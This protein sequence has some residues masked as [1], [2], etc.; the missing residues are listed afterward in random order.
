MLLLEMIRRL[1]RYHL[2][3]HD[4]AL[5]MI[6]SSGRPEDGVALFSHTL[7]ADDLWLARIEHGGQPEFNQPENLNDAKELLFRVIG[8]WH[9]LESRLTDEMLV[10]S[11]SYR[12]SKG[13]EYSQPLSDILMHVLNHGTH[14]RG[15]IAR[16]VRQAEGKPVNTDLLFYFRKEK[17]GRD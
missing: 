1:I 8:R 4:R 9:T 16:A 12:N 13:A 11:V 17:G 2:W 6:E 7:A 5:K 14:H 3:G 15:Q 10:S